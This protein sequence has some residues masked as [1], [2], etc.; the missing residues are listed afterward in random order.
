M[1][2]LKSFEGDLTFAHKDYV[3]FYHI[4][5]YYGDDSEGAGDAIADY[6]Y[7]RCLDYN[8]AAVYDALTRYI[9][10]EDMERSFLEDCAE[11]I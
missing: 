9:L 4:V 2:T 10:E 8:V 1:I 11:L 5:K 3:V 6:C 7:D